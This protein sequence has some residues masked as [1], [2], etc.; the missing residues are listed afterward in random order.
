MHSNQRSLQTGLPQYLMRRFW[1]SK[2]EV[3]PFRPPSDPQSPP[4]AAAAS[5]SHAGHY[6]GDTSHPAAAPARGSGWIGREID[7][8]CVCQQRC[9][10]PFFTPPQPE[11]IATPRSNRTCRRRWRPHP[12]FHPRAC[13]SLHLRTFPARVSLCCRCGGRRPTLHRCPAHAYVHVYM[14]MCICIRIYTQRPS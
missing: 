8:R 9:G 14:Y 13:S 6:L 11:H 10:T 1:K 3:K 12:H 5:A 7:G 2:D 4:G